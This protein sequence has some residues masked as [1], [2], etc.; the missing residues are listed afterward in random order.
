MRASGRYNRRRVCGRCT[1]VTYQ[2]ISIGHAADLC[3][4][5]FQVHRSLYRRIFCQLYFQDNLRG[6]ATTTRK[7]SYSANALCM[8]CRLSTGSSNP[9]TVVIFALS[10]ASASIRQALT[11]RPSKSTVQAPHWPWLQPISVPVRPSVP[12]VLQ[13]ASCEVPQR[14]CGFAH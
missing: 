2:P 3:I 6:C 7:A 8:G 14:A 4:T 1:S 11:W 9:S 5:R 12:A 10:A 13:P